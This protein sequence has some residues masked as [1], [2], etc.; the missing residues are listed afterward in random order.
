MPVF[1]LSALQSLYASDEYLIQDGHKAA[2]FKPTV[3]VTQGC[4]SS[5]LLF[6]LHVNDIGTIAEGVQGAVTGS[7]DVRVVLP[8]CTTVCDIVC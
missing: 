3:G 7:E 2:R 4:P 8:C 6:S 5:P 1:L